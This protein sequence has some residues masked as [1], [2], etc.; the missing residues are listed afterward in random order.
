MAVDVGAVARNPGSKR[1]RIGDLGY[2]CAAMGCDKRLCALDT[3]R[4]DVFPRTAFTA[5]DMAVLV[6]DLD[7]DALRRVAIRRGMLERD[8]KRNG[9]GASLDRNDLCHRLFSKRI[10]VKQELL[11][12]GQRHH[13]ELSFSLSVLHAKL[14]ICL[15]GF[16]AQPGGVYGAQALA[17]PLRRVF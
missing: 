5:A 4:R 7:P 1:R 17:F 9:E 13:L 8:A 12:I 15:T 3:L 16:R 10:Q 11:A 14:P 6:A 2:P